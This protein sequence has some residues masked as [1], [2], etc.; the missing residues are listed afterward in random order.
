MPNILRSFHDIVSDQFSDLDHK[1]RQLLTLGLEAF[2]LSVGIVSKIEG[3]QYEVLY[4]ESDIV[5][6]APGTRFNVNDTYCIHTLKSRQATGF[7]HVAQSDIASHPCYQAQQLESYLG[8]C[9]QV[10]GEL[11]G[12]VNFSSPEPTTPFTSADYDYVELF[13][14]WLGA[15][16]ARKAALDALTKQAST[17]QKLES[18]GK[19][20]TW[21]VDMR[22]GQIDWSDQ[23]RRIHET[24]K[25]FIPD[26]E[27]GIA[28]YKPGKSRDAISAAVKDTVD[29]GA[30]WSLKA[31]IVTARGNEK[32]VLTKG[33]AE[34]E[35]G[36]CVRLF[37]T[38]QDISKAEALNRELRE[39][40]E[41]A[42]NVLKERSALMAKI[43]HELRT[44]LN[45]ILGLLDN[46]PQ[47]KD[48]A[49][50]QQKYRLIKRSARILH[51]LIDEVL[52]FSKINAGEL[53]LQK[54]PTNILAM[55]VDTASIY[56]PLCDD[57]GLILNTDFRVAEDQ[58]ADADRTRVIQI[59]TNLMSNALKF[60]KQ[61]TISFSA[62][63]DVHQNDCY[64]TIRIADTGKGMTNE[65]VQR[66]FRPFYQAKSAEG[67]G[68]TGLGLS[69]VK[70]LCQMMQGDVIV[71]SE[72]GK[73]S[74]FTVNL[75]LPKCQAPSH[76]DAEEDVFD[77]SGLTVLVVDDNEINRIVMDSY[78]Q[79]FN[80]QCHMAT[81]GC[82]AITRCEQNQY[83][84]IF[85]DC[86]MP[87][88]DGISAT[89][90]LY[91]QGLLK[92]GASV[93]ALTANTADDDKKACRDAGMTFFMAKPVEMG[94][95]INVLRQHC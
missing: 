34:F 1:T 46:L 33:E 5:D 58:W 92:A 11:Y 36:E 24:S 62:H 16:I 59:L 50:Q 31:Q 56:Q 14:Q 2:G 80:I 47:E 15:E 81:D 17:L 13:A 68:G 54:K 25:D 88:L 77:A 43:S 22:S 85:M 84:V 41:Q 4:A 94:P 30:P 61:G 90:Q 12:T 71:D 83:D 79:R 28:F 66:L 42:E 18:V 19:I 63:S 35:N 67:S 45:G 27:S 3:D 8:A 87:K 57:K 38:F 37:G 89:R 23:T 91:A 69:I 29:T 74:V 52:D 64:L 76:T 20:G 70:E 40:K 60:T 51:H 73:G 93:V 55:L 53:R 26:I 78:L 86:V 7:H 75:P 49:E 72:E 48:E 39:Q 6:I 65:E 32:W 95:I 9:I 44:P 82:E 21:S 10:N